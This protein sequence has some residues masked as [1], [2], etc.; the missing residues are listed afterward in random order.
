[1]TGAFA[2]HLHEAIAI[3]TARRDR[4]ARR[5]KGRSRW[6]S[7]LLIT[8]ERAALPLAH[9]M[10]WRARGFNARGL[11]IVQNDFASMAHVRPW[12]SPPRRK[13]P[14]T[15]PALFALHREVRRFRRAVVFAAA[16]KN[17]TRVAKL[18]SDLLHELTRIEHAEHAHLAMTSHLVESIGLAAANAVD[19]STDS[20]GQ[21]D[22]LA[23]DLV[24]VQ[25]VALS[26]AVPID[27]MA[28]AQHALGIGILVNDVPEIAFPRHC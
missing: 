14:M 17:F 23:R 8:S 12:M 16:F 5:T 3:N 26:A 25:C 9:W 24:L 6:L 18:C 1:M 28:Q 10:D 27:R 4:Y 11:P 15:L 19:Y 22:G 13:K 20:E 2:T 7:T 21:T